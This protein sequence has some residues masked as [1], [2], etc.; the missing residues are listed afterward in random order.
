[1]CPSTLP[2]CTLPPIF[3]SQ[4]HEL[5]RGRR[6]H[7][8]GPGAVWRLF[9]ATNAAAAEAILQTKNFKSYGGPLG[10]G[11]SVA[12]AAATIAIDDAMKGITRVA[13]T[14]SEKNLAPAN[15]SA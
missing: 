9:H 2:P 10:V 7:N 4:H 5:G 6:K 11:L 14:V 3:K 12:F 1:M 13:G 8:D 15:F